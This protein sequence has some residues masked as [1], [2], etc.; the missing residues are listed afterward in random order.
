MTLV[1]F[2][3][4]K[5]IIAGRPFD[6]SLF[7]EIDRLLSQGHCPDGRLELETKETRLTCLIHQSTTYLAGLQEKD[8]FSWVPLK[9]FPVRALQ[10]EDA[11]CSLIRS[12]PIR[13]LLVAV[14]FRNRPELQASTELVDL[15]HVIDVLAKEGKDAALVLER[16]GCR[17]FLF[18]QKG[19]P[20]CLYFGNPADDPQEGDIKDRFLLFAFNPKAGPG[21]VEAFKHL[22]IDPDADAGQKLQT[23]AEAAKPPPA[24]TI[25]VR[26]GGR[27]I[28]QRP[29]M[30]PSITIGRDP[31]CE[32][33]LDNL[34]VSRRHAKLSWD[35]GQ[36]IIEDLG[37]ANWTVLAGKPIK[38]STLSFTDRVKLGKFE[39]NLSEAK[40]RLD[41]ES[42]I[43]MSGD[44]DV[45]LAYLVGE[46]I[47]IP[48]NQEITIG[49]AIGVDLRAEGF[50]VRPIH[51][52][53]KPEAEGTFRVV[54]T[55]NLKIM[56]N[57][58]KVQ[59]SYLRYG[60]Q[61]VLGR[62]RFRL[63]P[64]LSGEPTSA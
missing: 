10:M 40:E 14:H 38:R 1:H 2:P 8:V 29:F 57:G 62:S 9:D 45:S 17:T 34:S 32:L 36:F 51:A 56:V 55:G 16:D 43:I 37:S 64:T 48:L 7:D 61:I 23:L 11:V 4:G 42:T 63:V 60:D 58:K 44:D 19:L 25:V 3:P 50:W 30:P 27:V 24:T 31:S 35:R 12:D 47:S 54:C 5:K 21:K 49:K 33:L 6:K 22:S 39:L 13:V 28:L 59:S 20:T 26:L 46:N 53:I 52:R 15:S 18:F 41:P